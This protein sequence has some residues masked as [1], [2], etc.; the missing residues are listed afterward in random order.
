V[1]YV[2][3]RLLV[4]RLSFFYFGQTN[5]LFHGFNDYKKTLGEREARGSKVI[6]KNT[7]FIHK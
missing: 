6:S 2:R 1:L 3:I 7:G 4:E 5:V